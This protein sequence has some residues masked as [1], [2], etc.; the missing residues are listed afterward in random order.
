MAHAL[1]K[2][3]RKMVRSFMPGREAMLVCF[4]V[5]GQLGV[6]VVGDH[7]QVML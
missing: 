5:V 6:N 7:D 1:E 2:P 3:C 4:A